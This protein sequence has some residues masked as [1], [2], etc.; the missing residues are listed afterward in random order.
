MKRTDCRHFNGYKPCVKNAECNTN[1]P[2][3]EKPMTS[4]LL[5]H[6]GA[7]GAV[8]RSTSLLQSI[9]QKYPNSLITWITE[10]STKPL[11]SNNP[12]IDKVLTL[13]TRDLLILSALKFDI[14]FFIDKSPEVAGILKM[15]Q[16][17]Q[18]WGFTAL[19]E[20]GGIVPLTHSAQELWEIGLSNEKK[21]FINKKTEIQLIAEALELPYKRDEY[22]LKLTHDEIIL[23]QLRRRDWS[24]QG[25]KILLGFNTGTSGVLPQKTIADQV[26]VD[27]IL[28]LSHQLEKKGWLYQFVLLGGGPLDHQRNEM[29]AQHCSHLNLICSPTLNGLRD[30][31]CSTNAV[32]LVITGDSLGMHMAVA[33]K[34]Y[35]IAWFGPTCAHEIDLLENGVK[36]ESSFSC[37]P[38]WKRTCEIAKP[39]NQLVEINKIIDSVTKYILLNYCHQQPLILNQNEFSKN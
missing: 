16:P 35:V 17:T 26:W 28:Q 4:I 5:V 7:M 1:C 15:T 39:C 38:C 32:D 33:L 24:E 27:M 34:K 19:P 10:E 23:T 3:F 6:L 21:F 37:S 11:L 18:C 2:H 8:L 25:K 12:F 29:I 20:N 13:S 14:G 9:K 31:I 22:I 30:G 36:I